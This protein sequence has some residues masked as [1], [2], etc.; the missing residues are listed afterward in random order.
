MLD[1][2]LPGMT[3]LGCVRSITATIKSIDPSA[4]VEANLSTQ[5]ARI[6]SS[7]PEEVIRKAMVEGG[8]MP[9]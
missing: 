7:A 5:T 8:F 2:S 9:A 4:E 1:L 3:C 6:Q